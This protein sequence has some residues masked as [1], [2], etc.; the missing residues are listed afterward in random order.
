MISGPVN[1]NVFRYAALMAASFLAGMALSFPALAMERFDLVTTR[2]LVSLIEKKRLNKADFIL[3]ST[4]DEL[5]FKH[6]AIPGSVNIPWN[7]ARNLAEKKLGP[8]RSRLVI[9]YCMG[10]R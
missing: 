10:Y 1:I 6:Q 2:E 5:I 8:D 9:T 4:L 7:R 3:V